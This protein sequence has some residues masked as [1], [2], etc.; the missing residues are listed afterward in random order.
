MGPDGSNVRRLTNNLDS[1]L[2]AALS[3]DGK[4]ISFESNR[5]RAPTDPVN[6]SDLFVMDS[7]GQQ[8]TE[9]ITRAGSSSWSPDSK[10]LAFHA[11]ASGTGLPINVTPGAATTDSD[12]FVLNI[13]DC[14]AGVQG[15]LNLTNDPTTIDDD[16]DWSPD[17]QKIVFTRHSVNDPGP[18]FTTAEIWVMNADGSNKQQVTL[19][20]YDERGPAWSPDGTKILYICPAPWLGSGTDFE[21]LRHECRWLE[22]GRIDQQ[23][24]VRRHV[25]LVTG[26]PADR[27][28]PNHQ[29]HERDPGDER[30][31]YE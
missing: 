30:R 19:N 11:S 24:R 3:A 20:N 7:D 13:D 27:I 15:A 9:L 22:P 23:H 12:I 4:K 21:I 2:F 6:V 28:S 1:D 29:R 17:G 14:I 25:D 8:Q 16:P 18:Q 26:R 5:F 31:R 10:N